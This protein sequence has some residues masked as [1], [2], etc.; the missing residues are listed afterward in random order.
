MK[1]VMQ[2]TLALFALV[3]MMTA[4][5]QAPQIEMDSAKA[6]LE[7]AK[8]VEADRYMTAEYNALADSLNAT[9]LAIETEQ[10]KSAGSRDFKPFVEKLTEIRTAAEALTANA[11]TR[12]AEV[13]V[14]VEAAIAQLNGTIAENKDLLAKA[15]KIAGGKE[16][17]ELLQNEVAGLEASVGELNTLVSNGDYLTAFGKVQE[18]N[19]KAV[20]INTQLKTVPAK[21]M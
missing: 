12:K 5:G 19:A 2:G 8:T 18:G 1:K 11:E 17:L 15:P 14:E 9:L 6:A 20:A 3:L 21:K 4:C 13:R 7:A 16:A 10:A